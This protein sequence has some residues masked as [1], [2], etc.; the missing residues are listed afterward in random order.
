MD[1]DIFTTFPHIMNVLDVYYYI[2]YNSIIITSR[3]KQMDY[4]LQNIFWMDAVKL[5]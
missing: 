5:K 2:L 1:Y 4:E 3:E